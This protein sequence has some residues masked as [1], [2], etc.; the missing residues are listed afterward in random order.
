MGRMEKSS[1]LLLPAPKYLV[2]IAFFLA[3]LTILYDPALAI[4]AKRLN[5]LLSNAQSGTGELHGAET[6]THLEYGHLISQGARAR[7]TGT[8]I[9]SRIEFLLYKARELATGATNLINDNHHRRLIDQLKS[10][11]LKPSD[12]VKLEK[13][14]EVKKLIV[15]CRQHMYGLSIEGSLSNWLQI[16]TFASD[17]VLGTMFDDF[18]LVHDYGMLQV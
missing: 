8:T 9:D 5:A 13:N 14:A 3:A 15:D 12:V 16:Y 18:K 6:M 7:E 11:N 2:A 1:P 4:E 17:A 10:K